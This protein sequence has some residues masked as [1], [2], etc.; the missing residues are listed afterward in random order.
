MSE[1]LEQPSDHRTSNGVRV[2]KWVPFLASVALHAA[3]LGLGLVAYESV[4]GFIDRHVEQTRVP[5]SPLI[6][7][8]TTAELTQGIRGPADKPLFK[9]T[10]ADIQDAKADGWNTTRGHD[11]SSFSQLGASDTAPNTDAEAPQVI[12]L[13]PGSG[14]SKSR[15]AENGDGGP[16]AP[17]GAA[18][19]GGSPNIFINSTTPPARSVAFLCDAS[20]SMLNKFSDLRRELNKA[21]QSL[22]PYQ[23]FA[24][25]FFQGERFLSFNPQLLL[26]NPENKL[27]AMNFLE[28][29]SPRSTTDPIPSL[30]LAFKQKPQLV[31]LLTDGDFPDNAAVLGKIRQLNHDGAVKINTIAFVG[32]ADTD[33]AFIGLLKQI[34]QENGGTYRHVSLDQLP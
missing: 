3:V 26:A 4:K 34:A 7:S 18:Q 17:F 6:V 5:E 14:F 33:T 32:Q 11:R 16:L 28:D 24:I 9:P 25:T 19:R 21:I 27:R 13:G 10:Q 8:P 12:G 1:S 23:S 15:G 22:K 29:V 31:F 20:G 30:E 2:Q